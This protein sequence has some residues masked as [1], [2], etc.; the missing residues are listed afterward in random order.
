MH[1]TKAGRVNGGGAGGGRFGAVM[2]A[3]LNGAIG[4]RRSGHT[5]DV[6]IRSELDECDG[7][8]SHSKKLRRGTGGGGVHG[9]SRSPMLRRVVLRSEA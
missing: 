6:I 9:N 2:A 7:L 5:G 8:T 1:L 4:R 3:A